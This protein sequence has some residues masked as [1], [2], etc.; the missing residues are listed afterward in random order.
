M[1]F[2]SM[3]RTGKLYWMLMGI[4]GTL[5]VDG[6]ERGIQVAAGNCAW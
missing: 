4:L 3:H 6:T 1:A 2:S 5:I